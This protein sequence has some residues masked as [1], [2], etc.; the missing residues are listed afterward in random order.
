MKKQQLRAFLAVAQHKSIR[1]AARSLGLTQP[2]ITRIVRELEV[3]LD[4]PLVRRSAAGV[5]LTEF[6]QALE[7][8]ARL[9]LEDMRKIREEL[10]RLKNRT[11]GRVAL[12]VSPT[13]AMTVLPRAFDLFSLAMPGAHVD[14]TESSPTSGIE[15][16][17]DGTLDFFVTHLL[18]KPSEAF[19]TEFETIE[20]FTCSFVIGARNTHP[21][22]NATALVELLDERW[23]IQ[24]YGEH[25]DGL[26]DA[27]FNNNRLAQP[28]RVIRTDTLC[29]FTEPLFALR[30][31]SHGLVAIPVRE[32]LPATTVAVVRRRGMA[33]TPAAKHFIEC[34]Q[35]S[36]LQITR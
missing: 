19:L 24:S 31:M 14:L 16:I 36:A 9:L 28:N 5:D 13:V 3:E 18:D 26:V 12:A 22:K 6:G 30:C 7:V 25:G 23:C 34:L 35:K 1:G 20:L 27:I 8:R 29:L 10:D 15:A 17:R 32:A 21:Q 2:A 11:G 4:V 33:L